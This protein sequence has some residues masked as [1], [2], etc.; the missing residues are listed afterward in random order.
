MST[1]EKLTALDNLEGLDAGATAYIDTLTHST[2][3]YTDAAAGAKF[4]YSVNDGTGSSSVCMTLDGYTSDQII[5]AGI[6]AGMIAVWS[7]AVVDIPNGWDI[8]DGTNSTPDLRDRFVAGVG[9]HY[10]VGA[11][12][13]SATATMGATVTIAAHTL[14]NT[15]T[16]KH[17]HGTITD[18]Y[19]VH[20]SR[21]V[22]TYGAIRV[23]NAVGTTNRD[24]SSTGSGDGHTHTATWTA[25]VDQNKMPSYYALCY[26]MRS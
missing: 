12:G 11:T 17:T 25:T 14:A 16:P 2:R 22:Y 9:S 10:A 18:V 1:A 26:I 5:A 15:E 4:F 3:Y 21:H 13:G 7:G 20:L 6:P 24:T 19:P 23:V 8:C